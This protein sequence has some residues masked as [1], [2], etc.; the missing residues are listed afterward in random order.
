MRY[1]HDNMLPSRA[2][3]KLGKHLTTFEGGEDE[4]EYV[5]MKPANVSTGFGTALADPE[6]GI[7]NYQLDPRLAQMRDVFY[8]AAN[9]FLPTEH[10]TAF[11][12]QVS[13]QGQ[14]TYG[15]SQ[16]FLN[17]ALGLN[18][19]Q[20][21]Q[22]YYSDIQNLMR[23]DRANEEARLAD[24]LFKTGRSGAASAYGGGYL[25]PEQFALLKAREQQNQQLAIDA[26]QYG[27]QR[28]E[29]DVG[30]ASKLGA[31]GLANYGIGQTL[32]ADPYNQAAGIFGMGT[33][34]ESLGFKPLEIGMQA[35]PMHAQIQAGK[36]AVENA[37]A[38]DGKGGGLLG[39]VA[40]TAMNMGASY[41]TGGGSNL[42][43]GLSSMWSPLEGV[44]NVMQFG[45][46]GVSPFAG[47]YGIDQNPYLNW[48]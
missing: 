19:A 44:S 17:Q 25:N 43:G 30:F 7:Y 22:Q 18:T 27:R 14:N 38:S 28:R 39:G 12:N 45:Y 34:I 35:L 10:Q 3:N 33:G 40:D 20:L 16:D 31:T 21:G 9:Q 13:S 42:L 46:G 41:L 1:S 29:G 15:R 37:N 24:T 4:A 26:E 2:F 23:D 8:G 48:K 6:N 11:A 47:A 32:R 5:P 36:Q